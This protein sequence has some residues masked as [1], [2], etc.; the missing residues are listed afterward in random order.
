MLGQ[1]NCDAH[2]AASSKFSLRRGLC[3]VVNNHLFF[4]TTARPDGQAL[5]HSLCTSVLC[6]Q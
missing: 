4:N 1:E 6:D 5:V 3:A 2:A